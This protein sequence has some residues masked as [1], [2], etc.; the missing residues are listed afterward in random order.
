M[1]NLLHVN[2][3]NLTLTKHSRAY[4]SM[5]QDYSGFNS[6]VSTRDMRIGEQMGSVDIKLT[7]IDKN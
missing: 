4:L 7:Y 5:S 1:N 6:A 2:V 3:M